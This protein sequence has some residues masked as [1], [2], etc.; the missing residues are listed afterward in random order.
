[1]GAVYWALTAGLKRRWAY[2]IVPAGYLIAAF[3]ARG[4]ALITI[5]YMAANALEA[6]LVAE[7][8]RKIWRENARRS[9]VN[10]LAFIG[11]AILAPAISAFFAEAFHR[12]LSPESLE[13]YAFL[14]WWLA[15]SIAL[16][17]IGPAVISLVEHRILLRDRTWRFSSFVLPTIG[18]SIGVAALFLGE[19]SDTFPG[20]IVTVWWALTFGFGPT[21][22]AAA[23]LSSAVATANAL[24][25]GP[26]VGGFNLFMTQ[27][28]VVMY[29]L[30][31][32]ATAS[33]ADARREDLARAVDSEEK[34]QRALTYDP[35][36]GL[37]WRA[38]AM[39]S[40]E[41]VDPEE[42]IAVAVM[43][44]DGMS[45]INEVLGRSIGDQVLEVLGH[46]FLLGHRSTDV[47][48]R[49]GG[50]EFLFIGRHIESEA[51][52]RIVLDQLLDGLTVP[53]D[54][55]SDAVP[56]SVCAS[57]TYGKVSDFDDLLREADNALHEV[58]SKGRGQ[59][60]VRTA[61]ERSRLRNMKL[62]GD[63]FPAACTVGHVFCVY[64]PILPITP[65]LR[66]GAEALVRWNHPK[67]GQ[68]SP[69]LF[70]P[71]LERAG[72][73]GLLGNNVVE[74]SLVQLKQ[75]HTSGDES[76]PSFVSINVHASELEQ[77]QL[78]TKL[79]IACEKVNLSPRSLIL[80]LTE[81]AMVE[82]QPLVRYQLDALRE[83]GVKI[84]IDDFGTGYSSLAYLTRLP[85][86][87]LKLGAEFL[88]GQT[89]VKDRQLMSS[90]CSMA[91]D[92][93]LLTIVE[94][95]ETQEQL[96]SAVAAGANAAQGYLLG[97]P[98]PGSA[99]RGYRIP[100]VIDTTVGPEQRV[101]IK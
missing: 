51:D 90:I 52:V 33:L 5:A 26:F 28:F 93:G 96:L 7:F 76:A 66:I 62:L 14:T 98:G 68:L 83:A 50:D 41:G 6:A 29:S 25:I 42:N 22:V 32:L 79:I 40:L 34:L 46:R 101:S 3:P 15:D 74:H 17:A 48:A 53:A 27:I 87:V 72:H 85:V 100:S 9:T 69:G 8:V 49:L 10:R 60:H 24:G 13:P 1:M 71:A 80:E 99:L 64:Q 31:F 38:E 11:S 63:E 57:G 47:L 23:V 88:G 4:V 59:I 75:W 89:L 43:D 65:G 39:K 37:P 55:G 12:A 45:R 61:V 18:L 97:R 54:F 16:I 56:L 36:T 81:H 94:G 70:I 78:H 91:T 86:D 35:T 30:A 58:K 84:A 67:R 2:A 77:G 95:V 73:M 44:V 19:Y 20:L 82:M 92:V 21:A